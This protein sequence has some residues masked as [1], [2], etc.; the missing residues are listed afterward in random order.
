M[1]GLRHDDRLSHPTLIGC[2]FRW[3]TL[4]PLLARTPDSFIALLRPSGRRRRLYVCLHGVLG[5]FTLCFRPSE[6]QLLGRVSSGLAWDVVT[7]LGAI[8]SVSCRILAGGN[9]R[10]DFRT[11]YQVERSWYRARRG[12]C[13]C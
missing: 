5:V 2:E 4:R 1:F 7:S 8:G 12:L 13:V 10:D 3:N 11:G 9:D 6:Q